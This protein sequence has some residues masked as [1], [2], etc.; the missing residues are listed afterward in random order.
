MRRTFLTYGE[1]GQAIGMTGIELRNQMRHVLDH[2][3][4]A[5]NDKK[6]PSLAAL[7]DCRF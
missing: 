7:V 2:L 4:I 5:C 3:S 6:E 1:L